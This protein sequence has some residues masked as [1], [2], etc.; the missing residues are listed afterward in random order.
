MTSLRLQYTEASQGA[1]DSALRT[2]ARKKVWWCLQ[3]FFPGFRV[4]ALFHTLK[5]LPKTK[6]K[7]SKEGEGEEDGK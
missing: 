7:T 5:G 6:G 1:R 3:K 2:T 4:R